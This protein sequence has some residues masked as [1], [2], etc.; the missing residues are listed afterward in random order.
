MRHAKARLDLK[1]V[2]RIRRRQGRLEDLDILKEVGHAIEIFQYNNLRL[3][4][5]QLARQDGD[6]SFGKSSKTTSKSGT[7]ETP[8]LAGAVTFHLGCGG[9]ICGISVWSLLRWLRP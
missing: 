7:N 1:I 5:R 8:A 2:E 9:A 3:G 4:R 6:L